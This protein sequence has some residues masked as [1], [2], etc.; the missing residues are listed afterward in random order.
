ME[1]VLAILAGPDIIDHS[2][3]GEMFDEHHVMSVSRGIPNMGIAFG[4]M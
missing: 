1:V 4:D 2:V 3:K